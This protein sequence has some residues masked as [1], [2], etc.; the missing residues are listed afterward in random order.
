MR[1]YVINNQLKLSIKFIIYFSLIFIS[2]NSYAIGNENAN[3]NLFLTLE[4]A[5]SLAIKKNPDL[6]I[7]KLER[8]ND[9]YAVLVQKHNFEPSYSY[10]TIAATY[11]P[12]N[13]NEQLQEISANPNVTLNNVYGTKF[14]VGGNFNSPDSKNL[15]S[16]LTLEVLQPLIRGFGKDVVLADL[17][18]ALDS[19]EIK[20]LTFSNTVIDT[21]NSVIRAYLSIIQAL[22]TLKIDQE[23]LKVL[24]KT[25]KNDQVEID[26][27]RMAK[28]EI[29][30]ARANA[31]SAH[32]SVQNDINAVNSAKL[33][34]IDFLGLS[35][36]TKLII[37]EKIN[38]NEIIRIFL[39]GKY[40]V[41]AIDKFKKL[42]L[43]NNIDYKTSGLTLKT[44]K[45]N[46]IVA[47][48]KKNWE[49]NLDIE[50]NVDMNG[51]NNDN[52]NF[53]DG[54]LE[55]ASVGLSLNIPVDDVNFKASI[56]HAKIAVQEAEIRYQ[57][58][59]QRIEEDAENKY[60]TLISS[61]AQ[62][63]LQEEAALMQRKNIEAAKIKYSLGR[64][65]TFEFLQTQKE[66]FNVEQ[67][68]INSK[69][70]YI[71]T[72]M[73]YDKTLGTTLQNWGIKIKE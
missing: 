19:E 20:K 55:Q 38:L 3:K 6:V 22:Q 11:F 68:L 25:V 31:A 42:S 1:L 10:G 45:R 15:N 60:N 2:M 44:A 17:R 56:T 73:D 26:V 27:G 71:S 18:N 8:I 23:N 12:D 7:S 62:A 50:K 30:Q 67:A 9:K 69:I 59:K 24:E 21:I 43:E 54:I 65:S 41:I 61:R 53:K 64:I 5:V 13:N 72:L 28:N 33:Q 57:Q 46:L 48:D 47:E 32:A 58:Q 16:Q 40:D 36:D 63:K 4:Q 49:L 37:P 66:V 52:T 29:Y 51:N 35:A 34:M 14:T 70:N 39:G